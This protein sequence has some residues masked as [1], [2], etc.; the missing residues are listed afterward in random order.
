MKLINYILIGI[1]SSFVPIILISYKQGKLVENWYKIITMFVLL[2]IIFM[3]LLNMLNI[4]NMYVIGA[5]LSIIYSSIGRF[6][7]KVPT[8]IFKME[9]PNYFH[10][11]ALLIWIP[12]YGLVINGIIT[13][14]NNK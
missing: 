13:R 2:N 5:I 14:I 4:N 3:P 9:D 10:L 7:F 8:N 11:Y 12:Y 6:I 1:L